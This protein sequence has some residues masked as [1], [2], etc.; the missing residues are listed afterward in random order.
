MGG[1]GDITPKRLHGFRLCGVLSP[2]HGAP[3]VQS[4]LCFPSDRRDPDTNWEILGCFPD[5]HISVREI[6]NHRLPRF[7]IVVATSL[8]NA[9]RSVKG[10]LDA[11]AW[12]S[13]VPLS[14]PSVQ[15][16]AMWIWSPDGLEII[17]AL[18]IM[19]KSPDE[20]GVLSRILKSCLPSLLSLLRSLVL[21]ETLEL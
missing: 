8:G 15:C 10:G 13:L 4:N 18:Q 5:S 17:S 19:K 21:S 11:P 2:R 20:D 14:S 1:P 7:A 3:G 6:R 9:N 12:C 16:K